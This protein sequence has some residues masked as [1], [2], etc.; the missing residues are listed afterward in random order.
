MPVLT[1]PQ[2]EKLSLSVRAKALVFEDQKSRALLAR[3]QQVAPS[4]AT[5][6]IA[7]ETGTGKEIVARH[8][9]ALSERARRPFVAV[10]CGAFSESLIEGD[11]FGHEKGAFTGAA[12][13]K[14]GWFEAADGG[15]LFLD[16]I[17]DL[18]LGAQVK[19]LRV[20]QEHEVVRLGSRNPLPVDVRLIAATNVRLEE[21]VAS[22]H[23]REDLFYR[24]AVAKV[25]VDALRDRPGDI[26]PLARYFLDVYAAKLGNRGRPE[27]PRL[28]AAAE[29]CLLSHPWMGNIRELENAIHH[30]L[31][32]CR[33][34]EIG[35][36][37][38]PLI[39]LP[40]RRQT[41][42]FASLSAE[43]P[44]PQ[45]VPRADPRAV[46]RKTL[47]EIYDEGAPDLWNEIEEMVMLTAYEHSEENQ[48][49]TA[50]L[51]GVS[52]NVVRA[53]LLQF[54]ALA[55][56]GR[57]GEPA[58]DS[59][60]GRRRLTVRI[61]RLSVGPLSIM[62]IDGRLARRWAQ[63]G[64]DIA[65]SSFDAGPSI[66]EAMRTDQIDLGIAGSIASIMGQ[67]DGVPLVCLA[68]EPPAPGASAIVVHRDSPI[69][70]V[71]DL[72][73]KTVAL[74]RGS[75]S[76]YL[77]LKALEEADL[78][79]D[80]VNLSDL[81]TGDALAAFEHRDFD[82]WAIWNPTLAM[83][84]QKSGARVLRDSSGLAG[85][86]L[87]YVGT[88]AFSDAHPGLVDDFL[89]EVSRAG[90]WINDHHE[91][92]VDLLA[93]HVDSSRS[94]ISTALSRRRFGARPL[95]G[96]LLAAQQAVADTLLRANRI[97]RRV[98]VKDALW[99]APPL[100]I[101]QASQAPLRARR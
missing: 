32:V 40:P 7:G 4:S 96:P 3:I 90:A 47:K 23:F 11:L 80:D 81:P 72:K 22:G 99:V 83:L 44:T 28:G 92:A 101:A 37:D 75:N 48:L 26:L 5:V 24:L 12:T 34:P 42:S 62:K 18:P 85:N 35:P 20:L 61:G 39:T 58:D 46:L 31:L 15:T 100:P 87:C 25:S 97:G 45:P 88:R 36:E 10:N 27:V 65:W 55:G 13:G 59:L 38:L 33:G 74:N 78:E 30:A 1:L 17:G 54:G 29:R 51:L 53:R 73:G 76:D 8:I 82:A 79:P 70:Q 2:G 98:A 66:I 50:R 77:V 56:A 57:E 52:R 95:D 41:G 16:E 69:R 63:R 86:F 49:R 94:A 93:A 9:H 68:A 43:P 67:A 14:A 64:I 6:L 84:R 71:S 60:T 91:A 21:A 89:E 19:L